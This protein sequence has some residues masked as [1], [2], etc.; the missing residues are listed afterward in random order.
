MSMGAVLEL[1]GGGEHGWGFLSDSGLIGPGRIIKAGLGSVLVRP[2][3]GTGWTEWDIGNP[4][5][6][7]REAQ[8]PLAEPEHRPGLAIFALWAQVLSGERDPLA[9][10]ES[11]RNLASADDISDKLLAESANLAMRLALQEYLQDGLSLARL[12]L[13]VVT[14]QGARA[15]PRMTARVQCEFLEV[16]R[17]CLIKVPDPELLR[18]AHEAGDSALAWGREQGNEEIVS[19]ASFRL[20]ALYLDPY[21][22]ERGQETYWLQQAA[23]LRR[24]MSALGMSAIDASDE[25]LRAFMPLPVPALRT[26]EGYLRQA[27][28]ARS[29]EYRGL[30]LKAL[31]QALAALRGLGE[32]ITS[33][34]LD[35]VAQEALSLL[36][37]DLEE[38]RLYVWQFLSAEARIG[39]TPPRVPGGPAAGQADKSAALIAAAAA[40][41]GHN[42]EAATALVAQHHELLAG[43]PDPD[44]VGHLLLELKVAIMNSLVPAQRKQEAWPADTAA[45]T[46]LRVRLLAGA[47]PPSVRCALLLA[48]AERATATGVGPDQGLQCVDDA[49][50]ADPECLGL[51]ED[52]ILYL[53]GRLWFD[54][55]GELRRNAEDHLDAGELVWAYASATNLFQRVGIDAQAVEA[56]GFLTPFVPLLS[57]AECVA[58]RDYLLGATLGLGDRADPEAD[59]T[60]QA[61]YAMLLG[62]SVAA[63]TT[64]DFV[65]LIAQLAKGTR[66]ASA[67]SAGWRT[68]LAIPPRLRAELS[69]ADAE[70]AGMLPAVADDLLVAEQEDWLLTSY[71]DTVESLPSDTPL[72]RLRRRQ[73]QLDQ[74]LNR[75]LPQPGQSV[76]RSLEGI[77]ELLDRR[78]MLLLM[79]PAMWQS[80]T[81]GTEWLLVT[82]TETQAQFVDSRVPYGDLA[83]EVG[84]RK[85]QSSP[86]AALAVA[87]RQGLHEDCEPDVAT[88]DVLLMLDGR[89]RLGDL[90]Q[91]IDE[92]LSDGHDHLLVAPHGPGHYVP[93]HLLGQPDGPLATRCAVS[94]LPSLSLLEPGSFTDLAMSRLHAHPPASFGLSYTKVSS[95]GLGELLYAE[96]EATEVAQALG[97]SPVLEERATVS[98]VLEALQ[99]AR[100]VHLSA[101]GRHNVD[102]PAF[103]VIQLAGSPGHLPAHRLSACDLRGL[104]L[105][106]L[107]ACDTALGRFDRADNLRGIPAALCL[108]G[109]RSIIGTLWQARSSAARVFFV[110]LYRSLLGGA[111][112]ADAYRAAQA[113]TRTMFPS[114]RDWGA[115]VLMGGLPE[116]Y[117][118]RE[119]K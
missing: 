35:A 43:R 77:Q 57:P 11:A 86:D 72:H 58:V 56:L 3:G 33:G 99:S 46:E 90:W 98:A 110:A 10:A 68:G 9:A 38:A 16:A 117:A 36:P 96:E 44:W 92:L 87:I 85:M 53:R 80:G 20:G 55:A 76:L 97:V 40:A 2:L 75:L 23:W 26:A 45:Q 18:T 100:Y 65:M 95:Q 104:S 42:P 73:R 6:P 113:E 94:V 74:A 1:R 31:V 32:A 70:E 119:L 81:W 59:R 41:A 115:F 116:R 107:S 112:V 54:R 17:I 27:V 108:A 89:R 12:L 71:A 34:D 28:A 14:G 51:S 78:Q 82:R 19:A 105:V 8:G 103:Q 29:G 79:V 101:H 118:S 7:P 114:Y 48:L 21:T 111:T 25:S 109:V 93:W 15:A 62:R 64:H 84:T 91:R 52:A 66:M 102:A 83:V 4:D 50:A 49:R 106:T 60:V 67:L 39:L 13:A 61:Y 69:Q 47:E 63:G 88:D 24:G 30:A 37:A 5:R 22:T